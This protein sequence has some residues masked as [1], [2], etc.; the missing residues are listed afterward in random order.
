MDCREANI[1]VFQ[2][3]I[4]IPNRPSGRDR[5]RTGVESGGRLG[6]EAAAD[7]RRRPS[8]AVPAVRYGSYFSRPSKVL[9]RETG[10]LPNSFVSRFD[11]V[12]FITG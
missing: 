7:G 9:I 11:T 4:A 12:S 3:I 6:W 5:Q 2:K 1:P 10:S 8:A